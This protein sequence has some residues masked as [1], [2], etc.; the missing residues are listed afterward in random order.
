M[1][2]G[3]FKQPPILC[4][5]QVEI[6]VPKNP[7]YEVKLK[8]FFDHLILKDRILIT[9]AHR[10]WLQNLAANYPSPPGKH[11]V[12][13]HVRYW[14]NLVF[15]YSIYE[16]QGYFIGVDIQT[17]QPQISNYF[18]EPTLVI[19]LI[20]TNFMTTGINFPIIQRGIDPFQPKQERPY[21]YRVVASYFDDTLSTITREYA[22]MMLH[23]LGI[24]AYI[25]HQLSEEVMQNEQEI[26]L[27]SWPTQLSRKIAQKVNPGSPPPRDVP[28]VK[29]KEEKQ[30]KFGD[31]APH[32]L[33]VID[34]ASSNEE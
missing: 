34:Y 27:Q 7:N 24:T 8:L 28:I 5:E 23:Y 16:S 21:I 18:E 9:D 2:D 33:C 26:W 20:L 14:E 6:F 19:K 17:L 32:M 29:N 22:I 3:L 11:P 1:S 31:D 4:A 12:L 13:E 15:G 30:K 10:K 25:F